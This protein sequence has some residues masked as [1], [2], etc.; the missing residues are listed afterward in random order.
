MFVCCK[1]TIP[2]KEVHIYNECE[3]VVCQISLKNIKNLIVCSFYRPPGHDVQYAINH[4]NL[5]RDI[6]TA[7]SSSLIWPADDLNLPGIDWKY[8]NLLPCNLPSS[9]CNIFIDF[10]LEYGFTQLVDFPTR[11]HNILDIFLTN[12]PSYEYVCKPLAGISNHEIVYV[13]SAMDIELQKPI[14]HRIYLWHKANFEH[15]KSL[16]NSLVDEF[17][18]KHDD[19]IPGQLKPFGKLSKVYVQAVLTRIISQHFH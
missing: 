13:T 1:D 4:C 16:V 10:M 2:C 17:L 11:E 12:R 18:T 15:I 5:F 6:C 7:Y 3:A 19:D 9:I 8:C 14:S